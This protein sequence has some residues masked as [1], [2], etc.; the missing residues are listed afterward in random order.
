MKN[1]QYNWNW[2]FVLSILF[3]I[4]SMVFS[5]TLHGG[6]FINITL[7]VAALNLIICLYV[8]LKPEQHEDDLDDKALAEM[9][10]EIERIKRQ[11]QKEQEEKIAKFNQMIAEMEA[12]RTKKSPPVD[13]IYFPE[14]N[15]QG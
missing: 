12:E 6:T 13:D 11:V 10:A 1:S 8:G 14:N 7:I 5:T 9:Y 4:I 2:W 15:S 3:L